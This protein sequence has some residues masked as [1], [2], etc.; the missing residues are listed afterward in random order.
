MVSVWNDDTNTS[1]EDNALETNV[2]CKGIEDVA[3]YGEGEIISVDG[4][5]KAI[6]SFED[7]SGVGFVMKSLEAMMEVVVGE[8]NTTELVSS[9][10]SDGGV[11]VSTIEEVKSIVVAVDVSTEEVL[12][13]M[14]E[15]EREREGNEDRLIDK[16]RSN[17]D[18][19]ISWTR[20]EKALPSGTV[21][22]V[23]KLGVGSMLGKSGS[24]ELLL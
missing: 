15:G 20:L 16:V 8:A 19:D 2:V 5:A 24:F 3:R 22:R 4:S 18:N 7:G 1:T 10:K 6:S 9:G 11:N 14:S 17:V 21:V 12:G 23:E 13:N